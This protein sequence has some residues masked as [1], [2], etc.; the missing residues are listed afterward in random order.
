MSNNFQIHA[1]ANQH[2]KDWALRVTVTQYDADGLPT[3]PRTVRGHASLPDV[4]DELD[5]AWIVLVQL[6]HMLEREGASGRVGGVEWPA[7]F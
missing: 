5:Q 3:E 2:G 1:N 6:A 4:Q 7:L